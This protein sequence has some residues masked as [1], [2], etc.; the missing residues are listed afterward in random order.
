MAVRE[1]YDHGIPNWLDLS[2]TDVPGAKAFYNAVFGW[3]FEDEPTDDGSIYTMASIG[4]K[5]VAG[6]FELSAEMAEGGMPPMWNHYIN[7]DDVE[8]AAAAVT[9]AGG[10]VMAPPFD[11]MDA[12]RMAVVADPTGAV[13]GLWQAKDNIGAE[14]VNEAGSFGWSEVYSPDVGAA[15]KFYT[16]VFGWKT[17]DMPMEDGPDYTLLTTDGTPE[18]GFAGAMPPPME[19]VPPH[20]ALWFMT[21]DTDGTVEKAK[22]AGGVVMQ[23]PMDIMPGRM[24]LLTDPAGAL[25]FVLQPAPQG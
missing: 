12:G 3:D 9:G 11:V 22:A 23:E 16:D 5:S 15:V 8:A 25:F 24:A 20:W 1:K 21:D 13:T 18:G 2:T 7:V 4:G 14:L 17:F 6:I 19:G 10:N